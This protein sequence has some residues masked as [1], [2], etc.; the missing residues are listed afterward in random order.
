M[1]VYIY[2]CVSVCVCVC[3]CT[4]FSFLLFTANLTEKLQERKLIHTLASTYS[5]LVA[6]L[7]D[8]T[9]IP[10]PTNCLI[11]WRKLNFFIFLCQPLMQNVPTK[12]VSDRYMS[13]TSAS[14][15]WCFLFPLSWRRWCG[16][17]T[18][19]GRSGA[20]PVLHFY[21]STLLLMPHTLQEKS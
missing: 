20:S 19:G 1:Y 7:Q 5:S 4:Y 15:R 14:R 2:A 16:W 10:T 3:V 11:T 8:T 13:L 21:T 17:D 6:V 9:S 12:L 18:S